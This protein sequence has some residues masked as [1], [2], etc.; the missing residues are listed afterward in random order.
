LATSNIAKSGEVINW[1]GFSPFRLHLGLIV[2]GS[3]SASCHTATVTA[4]LLESGTNLR[5]IQEL[6]GHQSLKTTEIYTHITTKGF[7]QIK[8]PLDNLE[9]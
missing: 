3:Q 4:H 1:G 8:S 9:I 7:D 5:L 2:N 6:L